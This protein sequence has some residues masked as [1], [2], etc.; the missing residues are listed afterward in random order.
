MH[1]SE[2]GTKMSDFMLHV[3][4]SVTLF[5]FSAVYSVLNKIPRGWQLWSFLCT[6]L[7]DG[8]LICCLTYTMGWVCSWCRKDHDATWCSTVVSFLTSY[9]LF[10]A[11]LGMSTFTHIV[12]FSANL[13]FLRP[14]AQ[15]VKYARIYGFILGGM[16]GTILALNHRQRLRLDFC[17]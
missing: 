13:A 14:L 2:E 7:T 15:H 16:A 1:L 3:V 6:S 11:A 5:R 10:G 9:F 4:A 8:L 12:R 17:N